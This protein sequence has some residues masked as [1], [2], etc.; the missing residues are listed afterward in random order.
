[1]KTR[2]RNIILGTCGLVVIG[3]LVA[4]LATGA[5]PY[6]RFR[7]HEVEQANSETDLSDLFAESGVVDEP[8]KAIESVNAI[9]FLPS[10]PGR[11]SISVL[12]LSAPAL[13]V[14]FFTLWLGRKNTT[15]ENRATQ[16]S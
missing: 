13:G 14:M 4:S 3:S 11:A 9:G 16:A 10:G 6:T 12:T 8:P 1:M 2:T 15:K 5:K 7:D